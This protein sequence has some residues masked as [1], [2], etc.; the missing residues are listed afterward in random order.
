MSASWVVLD[1]PLPEKENE[2]NAYFNKIKNG[3]QLT[4]EERTA[5]FDTQHKFSCY[6]AIGAPQIGIDS[7]ANEWLIKQFETGK[8]KPE[9]S[10]HQIQEQMNGYYVLELATDKGFNGMYVDMNNDFSCQIM[11]IIEDCP[12]EL[13]KIGNCFASFTPKEAITAAANFEQ[14]INEHIEENGLISMDEIINKQ[15]EKKYDEPDEDDED[16]DDEMQLLPII[17]AAKWLQYWGN[18]GFYI[19]MEV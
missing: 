16:A 6:M 15:Q 2:Y 4:E 14:A 3:E 13:S 5:F 19:A 7:A 9:L 18:K 10:L 1:K 12:F 8:Y 17:S 11:P